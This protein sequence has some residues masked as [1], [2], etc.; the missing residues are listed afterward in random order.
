MSLIPASISSFSVPKLFHKTW[1]GT[2]ICK[3]QVYFQPE[4]IEQIVELVNVARE[5][6]KSL[7]VVGSGHSPSDMTMTDEWLVN[8]DKFQKILDINVQESGKYTDVTVEAGIRIYQL[9][10]FLQQKGLAVQN[11]GSISEQSVAGIIST[12]THGASPF[13]GLVSQQ[14]VDIT[15]VNGKGELIKCSPL[16]NQEL[17]RGAMLSLGKLGMIVKVTLRTVP[18]YQIKSTQEI[19]EFQTLLKVWD[20][21]WTEDEFIRVWWFPYTKRCVLWRAS[22]S[23]EPLSKPRTSWYGTSLGRFFY[24]SLLWFAVHIYSRATPYIE[25][26]VFS[27]QYGLEETLGYGTSAV[28]ESVEGLNMDCL[29]SQFVNEWAAPLTNGPE[30]LRSLEHSINLAARNGDF[31]VHAPIEVRCSN[32]TTSNSLE[33]PNVSSRKITSPGPIYGND[34]RPLLDNTPRLNWVPQENVTNSQLT[35][36]INAT[37]YR[38]F[39]TSVPIGKWYQVFEETLEAAGG[40]PHWAKNFIGSEAYAGGIL[41]SNYKDGEMKGFAGKMDEWFGD[42]LKTFKRLRRQNDPNNVFL[43]GKDWAL[44]NGI[45]DETDLQ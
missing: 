30:I 5:K 26:F 7:M 43:S 11:L 32:T 28:E 38:P 21:I 44:R 17:F 31:F 24:E 20:T 36:Y 39:G 14:V 2:F 10:D 3:P 37:M 25:R 9:N 40:K 13:H 41:K 35:L 27:R 34:L 22:K 8:L 42:D 4:N 19:I 6:K 12:G 18:R 23:E 16:I 1:A 33:K 15:L 45:I 29:F